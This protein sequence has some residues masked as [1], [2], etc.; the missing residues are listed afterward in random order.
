MDWI[1]RRTLLTGLC[2][3]MDG[4]DVRGSIGTCVVVELFAIGGG[5]GTVTECDNKTS[6]NG[7]EREGGR[8]SEKERP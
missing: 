4:H 6:Q 3:R 8:E 1:D 5:R 7:T 2:E